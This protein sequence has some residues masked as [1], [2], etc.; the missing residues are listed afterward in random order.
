MNPKLQRSQDI[1]RKLNLLSAVEQ[2]RFRLQVWRNDSDNQLFQAKY[3]DFHLP[4]AHLAFDAHG[5]VNWRIYRESGTVVANQLAQVL[6]ESRAPAS[7]AS[8]RHILE[9]GCGPGRVIR[10]L[11]ARMPTDKLYGSDYNPE[12]I[13]WCTANIPNVTFIEN[14]LH[15]P[16]QFQSE[17][18]DAVYAI[19]VI[20]HLS[21][22]VC[23]EWVTEL[24]RI[25]KPQGILVLWSN[26]DHIAESLLP[27]EKRRY[28][29]G[30]FT[31]R[32]NYKEGKKM[33]LSFHP[34][35]WVRQ[36]LLSEFEVIKH[37][38]GGFSGNEQDVWIARKPSHRP[39]SI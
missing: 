2:M 14:G 3:P 20:T 17:F 12:S 30:E 32:T 1:L 10:H 25:I 22:P 31:E 39:M 11:Q 18:F 16:L 33:Y 36:S 15:P 19:S 7:S 28:G 24:K 34:P 21:E 6:Q 29:Q 23:H 27:E 37:Y 9:W 4:P 13:A 38:P 5:H 35:T 8:S 26:G